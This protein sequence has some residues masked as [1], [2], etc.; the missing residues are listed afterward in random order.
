VTAVDDVWAGE[1]SVRGCGAAVVVAAAVTCAVRA[2][3]V[4]SL[5]TKKVREGA[6]VHVL[7]RQVNTKRRL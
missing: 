2:T 5:G 4:R 3:P 7:L 1:F 6:C